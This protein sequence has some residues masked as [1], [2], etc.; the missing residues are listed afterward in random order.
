M[1]L[2]KVLLCPLE[3]HVW[4]TDPIICGTDFGTSSMLKYIK[5]THSSVILKTGWKSKLYINTF[6]MLNIIQVRLHGEYL[7]GDSGG[8]QSWGQ[9]FGGFS[10]SDYKLSTMEAISPAAMGKHI[11]GSSVGRSVSFLRG[12]TMPLGSKSCYP[13]VWQGEFY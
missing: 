5:S 9:R 12:E 8:S 10:E 7:G 6:N 13:L 3:P 1:E 2:P 4:D 11:R